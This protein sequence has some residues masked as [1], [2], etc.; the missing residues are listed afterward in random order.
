MLKHLGIAGYSATTADIQAIAALPG[1]E[2]ISEILT[3]AG[4]DHLLQ[5]TI[6]GDDVPI[7]WEA[8]DA[9]VWRLLN[10]IGLT[11]DTAGACGEDGIWVSVLPET[12]L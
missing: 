7:L 2:F 4:G 1:T 9:A 11:L 5:F 6:I 12:G 3:L 8:L 10:T